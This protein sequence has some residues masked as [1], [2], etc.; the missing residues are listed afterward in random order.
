MSADEL[1]GRRYGGVT[2]LL[3]PDRGGYPYGNSLL[4]NGSSAALLVDPSLAVAQATRVPSADAIF[5]SH[6]HEDHT[7]GLGRFTGVPIHAH[8]DDAPAIRSLD[9]QVARYGMD[10][11][12]AR[13]QAAKLAREFDLS[14]RPDAQAVNDGTVFDLG[15]R[16]ATV[17]H[18][19]GHT[20]GHSGLLVE[21]D[22]FLFLG[23]IDL[24]S[25]GPYYGDIASDVED[26][27][28]SVRRC[29][30][31]EA[32]WYATFHHK[33]VVEGATEFRRRLD[34][35][36]SAVRRREIELLAYLSEPRT[37]DDIAAH[38]L[39]Y[40]HRLDEVFVPALERR[41]AARHVERLLATDAVTEMEPGLFRSTER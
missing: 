40:R 18:L 6:A 36:W 15:G 21:P 16:T 39:I 13:I 34:T 23:D 12:A 35:Y 29:A 1:A 4:I 24:S 25:W 27:A 26:F 20:R 3:A 11:D 7:A 38:G 19:P 14:D 31:I 30:S 2:T 33:G 5:V 32:R 22:G 28:A 10:P 8:V 17:V 9:V 37:L 41:F